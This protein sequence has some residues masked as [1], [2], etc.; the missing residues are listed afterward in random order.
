MRN[1]ALVLAILGLATVETSAD[2]WA[3]KMFP[4][5][6]SYDHGS[7]PRG[8]E[9]Y[10]KFK[11]VNIYAV[12][13]DIVEL[14]PSCDCGKVTATPMRLEP[15]QEG[16]VEVTMDTR[17][18][19]GPRTLSIFVRVGPQF[20]STAELKVIANSRSDV[21]FNPPGG[22]NFG[23]VARGQAPTQT[24]D[25]EYAGKL[26][27]RINEVV[28]GDAPL[29]A[30]FE[31]WYRKPGQVGYRVKVSLKPEAP[32]GNHKWEL[33]LKTNDPATP[34]VPVL[35]EANTQAQLT[36][37]PE[38]LKLGNLRVNT[39]GLGRIIVRS[40]GKPFR[41]LA[42]EGLGDGLT[43]PMELPS[44]ESSSH[45]IMFHCQPLKP[46][47]LRRTLQIKTDLQ[48]TP[49]AVTVEANAIP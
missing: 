20:T 40:S 11:M 26:D 47:E 24:I 10:H 44:K 21:V 18:F 4:D 28:K 45:Q 14:R 3:E 12:P 17:R 19:T 37:L 38:T 46:G 5:G 23:V 49:V 42:I 43:A 15:R 22:V 9:L 1:A 13:L 27:W 25:V 35:V 48:E 33:F 7:I 34:L 2:S 30:A 16:Y 39:E 29:D 31:E 6:T 41:I 36:V 8:A 32:A